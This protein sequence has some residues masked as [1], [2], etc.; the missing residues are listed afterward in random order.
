MGPPPPMRPPGMKK[1][2]VV[3]KADG[4][5]LGKA[6][7]GYPNSPTTEVDSAVS[8]HKR[9]GGVS[10][11]AEGGTI[12]IKEGEETGMRKGGV[13]KKRQMGGGL[14]GQSPIASGGGQAS[15]APASAGLFGPG[16]GRG[17]T[18]PIEGPPTI[19]GR[20]ARPGLP[21]TVPLPPT[22]GTRLTRPAPGTTVSYSKKGGSI[23]PDEAQD[24]KLFKQMIKQEDKAE[25]RARGGSINPGHNPPTRG[26]PGSIYHQ[27][28][29]GLASGGVVKTPLKNATGGGA[30]GKGRLAKARA[31]KSVPDK[32]E[33]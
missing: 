3:K 12:D 15:S 31:A 9:G 32:T 10:K 33:L 21:L 29:K 24:K 8:A 20:P 4:G 30:G 2:G 14:G 16:P 1:G 13:V 17:P 28:G 26:L 7:R 18:P 5:G 23:H 27:Q 19:S 22:L 11:R 25:K 6:Y